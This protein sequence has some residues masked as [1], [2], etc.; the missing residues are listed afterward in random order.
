MRW[1]YL[2]LLLCCVLCVATPVSGTQK[3]SA[4]QILQRVDDNQVLEHAI[5]TATMIIHG[6]SGTRTI[7]S[8]S[9][10]LG[11]DQSFSEY[12]SPPREK[13]K[14][15]LKLGDKLWTYTPEPHD[16]IIAISGHL[17]K[18]SVMGSDLSYE[19]M[20]SNDSLEEDYTAVVIDEEN[21]GERPC[22]VLELTANRSDVSYAKRRIWV[23]SE[24]WLAI[25]SHLMAKSGKLL[26]THVVKDVF[27]LE[28]RW[29]PKVI[30]FKD[31]LARGGGTEYHLDSIDLKTSVPTSKFTKASL[32]R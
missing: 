24:R 32:R 2:V 6:R 5:V 8:R 29:Y 17:L 7:T 11:E 1:R 14:K 25:R 23:D 4:V 9:W 27:H 16:R 18:Q 20:M 13:G 3:L 22:F 19:D 28:D 21:V 10:I 12:L 31:M 26:K 15:M 30:F